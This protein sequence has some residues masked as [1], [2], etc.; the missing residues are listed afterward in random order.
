MPETFHLFFYLVSYSM[1]SLPEKAGYVL[2]GQNL[3]DSGKI[4]C[5]NGHDA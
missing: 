3:E 4:E 2:N 1:L 5:H